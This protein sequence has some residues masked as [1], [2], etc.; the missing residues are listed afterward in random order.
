M[1]IT[2][3]VDDKKLQRKLDQQIREQPRQV[4]KV[5]GRTAEF[6]MGLIKTRTQRGKNVDGLT[7]PPYSTKPYFFNVGSKNRPIY[8]TLDG[9][10]KE[11]RRYKGR[12]VNVVDLNF[13]G[14]MLSNMTQ[15]SNPKQAII[16]FADKF[17][18]TKA[19]GNQKKRKF[20][21]IGDRET[22]T[23][24][25]FFAKEFKKVNKLI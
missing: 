20:F 3:K 7:F 12:Q 25:N 16:Y 9:G 15:K 14:K 17:Q 11:F 2:P 21:G 5:L 19:V 8:K 1:K 4:Q 6:L 24:I 18:A 10:Y 23:L 22:S 13:S